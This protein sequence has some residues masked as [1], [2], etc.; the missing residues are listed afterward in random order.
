MKPNYLIV[1]ELLR[2]TD[3]IVADYLE[4]KYTKYVIPV[5]KEHG[6]DI[7]KLVESKL[8]DVEHI[9][10]RILV[11]YNSDDTILQIELL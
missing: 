11:F 2:R 9:N 5:G 10:V 7:S 4:C 1:K 8:R 3:R 6:Q